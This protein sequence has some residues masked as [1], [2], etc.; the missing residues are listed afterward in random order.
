M[1]VED[2]TEYLNIPLSTVLYYSCHQ[3]RQT[4]CP[5]NLIYSFHSKSKN[6]NGQPTSDHIKPCNI[7]SSEVHNRRT[8]KCL[9]HISR[10]KFYIHTDITSQS[11]SW[12]SSLMEGK[13]LTAYYNDI[14]RMVQE[15]TGRAMQTKERIVTNNKT[16]KTKI[17]SGSSPPRESMVVCK[18]N[19]TIDQLQKYR[20]R[21]HKRWS[22]T[23]LQIGHYS[24]PGTLH[25]NL[26]VMPTSYR[27][28]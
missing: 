26:T 20:D 22:I 13:D 9:K 12:A 16:D 3:T 21:C 18:V 24:I 2:E 6:K 1:S 11:S 7:G 25:G 14:A 5:K 23:A 8:P 27:T 28:G 15:K 17:I 19:T 4:A 10:E